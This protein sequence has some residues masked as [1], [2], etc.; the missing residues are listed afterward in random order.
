[1]VVSGKDKMNAKSKFTF[2]IFFLAVCL[3]VAILSGYLGLSPS[4]IESFA[5]V[6]SILAVFI[7][8]LLFAVLASFSFSVSAM[9]GLGVLFF[10]PSEVVV[11]AM[12]AIMISSTIHFYISRKL[13]RNYVRDYLEKRAGKLEKF[14][15]IVEKDTSKTIIIL[16]AIFFVPP[17]IPNLLGGIIKINLKRYAVATFFGNVFNTIFTVYLVNGIFNSNPTQI[18][19]SVAGLAIVTLIALYSYKGEIRNI[20]RISFPWLF[21]K[22]NS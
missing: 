16:S 6:N 10:S 5:A 17:I 2:F 7:Y 9:T 4:S 20:F 3:I 8:A 22:D 13:G 18:Y 14:D 21:R 19:V 1:M 15:E 12:I 11:C